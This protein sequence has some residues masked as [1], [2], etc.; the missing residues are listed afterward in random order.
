ML[1]IIVESDTKYLIS[2]GLKN[3]NLYPAEN[4]EKKLNLNY[5]HDVKKHTENTKMRLYSKKI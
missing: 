2:K 4:S 5:G 3:F 1:Y